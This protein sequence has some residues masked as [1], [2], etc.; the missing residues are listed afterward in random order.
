MFS[1][2]E[3]G[4]LV[5]GFKAIQCLTLLREEVGFDSLPGWDP[6]GS[7]DGRTEACNLTLPH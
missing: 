4:G 6:R 7:H 5:C 3:T 2:K 1:R